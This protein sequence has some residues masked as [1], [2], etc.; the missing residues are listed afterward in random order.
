MSSFIK[1]LFF[2]AGH[3]EQ[4]CRRSCLVT[5]HLRGIE[6]RGVEYADMEAY[7][8]ERDGVLPPASS[9]NPQTWALGEAVGLLFI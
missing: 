9:I 4:V 6:E 2:S 8:A 5:Y 7:T 1:G 3:L